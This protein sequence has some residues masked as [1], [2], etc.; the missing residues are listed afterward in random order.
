[1]SSVRVI[2]VDVNAVRNA[3]EALAA[4]LK[5][6]P[7]VLSVYLCGSWAR[8]NYTPYSDIDLLILVTNDARKPWERVPDYLPGKFPVGLDL[9]VYTPGELQNSSFARELLKNAIQL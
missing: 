7:E 4:K 1:M 5:S 2:S 8:G 6:R 9:F 3:L